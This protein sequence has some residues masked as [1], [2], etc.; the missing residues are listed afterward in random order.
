MATALPASPQTLPALRPELRLL[1]EGTQHILYDPVSHRYAKID[2]QTAVLLKCWRLSRDPVAVMTL[3]GA[4]LG[5]SF[6]AASLQQLVE[7]AGRSGW[8][9]PQGSAAVDKLATAAANGKKSGLNWL[10]HNWISIRIPLVSPEAMLRRFAPVLDLLFSKAGLVATAL[11]TL[12]ALW[13]A[14]RQWAELSA[15][16]TGLANAYALAGLGLTLLLVKVWHEIGHGH[17][18]M[19]HGCRVPNAG[20]MIVL[21]APLFYTDVSDAWRLPDRR[22]RM[23]IAAAGFQAEMML[24]AA[25]LL[26]W[27]FLPDG[28]MRSLCFFVAFGSMAASIFVNLSPFMRFDGYF[29]LSDWLRIP[30]LHAKAFAAMTWLLRRHLLGFADAAPKETAGLSIGALALFGALTATYRFFFFL[31]LAVLVYHMTFKILGILLFAIEI[32]WF[33]LKPLSAELK[34]WRARSDEIRWRGP[35]LR[36]ACA[37]LLIGLV[38]FLPLSGSVRVKAVIEPGETA[39]LH[40]PEA[41]KIVN[42]HVTAGAEVRRGDLLAELESPIIAHQIDLASKRLALVQARLAR[43]GADSQER[44]QRQVLL[45][46]EQTLALRLRGLAAE[47][48]VLRLRAP[49]D[50]RVIHLDQQIHAGRMVSPK[51][52]ILLIGGHGTVSARGMGDAI[53]TG[54][55]TEGAS[56]TFIAEDALQPRRHLTLIQKAASS[57]A[58]IEP[59]ALAESFGG[60][61][62]ASMDGKGRAVATGAAYLLTFR[63][64][65]DAP[66]LAQRGT[67]HITA[68]TESLAAR[69]LRR[70]FSILVRESGV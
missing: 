9:M 50:G 11:V 34:I 6:S 52:R 25:A 26:L 68:A 13:L 53:Q 29:L 21:G 2:F 15:A 8:L 10:L 33:I 38:M 16:F 3:A 60:D 41:A 55:L 30:N 43:G 23:E 39:R 63:G 36:S 22:R 27:V 12:V 70:A 61:T 58:V 5:A 56:A 49:I 54:R 44:A 28:L 40:A 62:P 67:I 46:E 37:L 69:G 32:A 42:L 7:S 48:D 4:R 24:A 18:A 51:D 17:I 57:S 65:G 64:E 1:D 14:S 47:Q 66:M 31:G 20:V 35:G 59:A 45:Q 19:R